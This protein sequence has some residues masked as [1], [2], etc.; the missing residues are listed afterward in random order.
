MKRH[1][2]Q[3][4]DIPSSV[5]SGI[6]TLEDMVQYTLDDPRECPKNYDAYR[7]FAAALSR[8]DISSE[9]YQH[10]KTRV[11]ESKT[12]IE[13]ELKKHSAD[14]VVYLGATVRMW[15]HAA[16]PIM[17]V[18]LGLLGDD[19]PLIKRQLV[20]RA[21]ETMDGPMTL[22]TMHPNKYVAASVHPSVR[23]DGSRTQTLRHLLRRRCSKRSYIDPRISCIRTGDA[24]ER[25]MFNIP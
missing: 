15:S 5:P 25:Q 7:R 13:E 2:R 6:R 12:L 21:G 11:D 10:L 24:T 14:A 22:Y 19:V 3:A 17:T 8:E 16:Y 1:E 23:T 4:S 18:P 20:N 9:R